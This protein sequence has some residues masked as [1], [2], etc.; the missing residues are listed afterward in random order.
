M[1]RRGPDPD[2]SAGERRRAP[3]RGGRDPGLRGRGPERNHPVLERLR[4]DTRSRSV[5]TFRTPNGGARVEVEEKKAAAIL[6][7]AAGATANPL[8][9]P[10]GGPPLAL[11]ADGTVLGP[12]AAADLDWA[13]VADLPVVRGVDPAAE[14]EGGRGLLAGRLAAALRGRPDIDALVSEIRLPPGARRI[15]VALRP[16]AVTVIL[17]PPD[18][19]GESAAEAFTT[20]LAFVAGLLPD[21]LTRWPRLS[22]VDA[23]VSRPAAAARATRP[24][25]P[26]ARRT[27]ELSANPDLICGIDIGT[28]AVR[29]VL[30]HTDPEEAEADPKVPEQVQIVAV[31]QAPTNGGVRKAR[32]VRADRVTVAVREAVEELEQAA[33]VEVGQ[34]VVGVCGQRVPGINSAAE[35]AILPAG[36]V[37]TAEDVRRVIEA[38]IPMPRA[39]GWVHL[40]H[41]VVHAL[42]QTYWLDD[43]DET[44]DPVG[45]RGRSLKAHIHL[46]TAPEASLDIVEEAVNRAGITVE[47]LVLSSLAAG[48]AVLHPDERESGALL[49]DVG[50]GTTGIA[51]FRLRSLWFS[52]EMPS[53]GANYT[54]DVAMG[55][56]LDSA[57]AE[58]VKRQAGSG[59]RGSGSRGRHLRDPEP[60]RRRSAAGAAEAS[61]LGAAGA[62]APRSGGDPG[63][64]PKV[65]DAQASGSHRR[66]R[67][68]RR[69]RR[70][71][72][73]RLRRR[74]RFDPGSAGDDRSSRR[75]ERAALRRRRGALSPRPQGP[76]APD[77]L[78]GRLPPKTRRVPRPPAAREGARLIPL[79]T[80]FS[81][82]RLSSTPLRTLPDPSEEPRT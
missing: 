65:A 34:A 23:P 32:V 54:R 18:R 78:R 49:L 79:E 15:E 76:P 67:R 64:D 57:T 2:R 71:G 13:G 25:G 28:E 66:G 27:P 26:R 53:G 56:Q 5:A 68:S 4:A 31:G 62:R 22:R 8:A 36:R 39:D 6:L 61:R 17:E 7:G 14:G 46:V 10:G 24:G 42:P 69:A 1:A 74:A 41:R 38:A 52:D 44:V 50:A 60:G 21:L 43:L 30:A 75:D 55:L 70:S 58:T 12:A 72:A 33:G 29:A 19:P 40:N 20:R 80:V 73:A 81:P 51:V 35:I 48:E 37:I 3:D 16:A 82:V 47:A 59:A 9:G 63:S 77:G 45:E 11:A